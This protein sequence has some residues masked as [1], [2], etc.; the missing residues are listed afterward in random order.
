MPNETLTVARADVRRTEI[1]CLR[2]ALARLLRAGPG[3]V[4]PGSVAPERERGGQEE[5]MQPHEDNDDLSIC[6]RAFVLAGEFWV[7][8]EETFEIQREVNTCGQNPD[9]ED[10]EHDAH[11]HGCSFAGAR[12]NARIPD[13]DPLHL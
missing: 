4:L 12:S 1:L 10:K 11:T 5:C 7:R 6:P 2:I 9:P 3:V 13:R 8:S